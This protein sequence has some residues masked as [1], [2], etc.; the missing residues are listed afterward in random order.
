MANFQ[1]SVWYSAAAMISMV[2]PLVNYGLG[3]IKGSLA[4]WRYMFIVAGVITSLWG[5]VVL[6]VMESD[7][8]HAKSLNAR[9]KFIAVSRLREN[10]AGVRNTHFKVSQLWEV[11]TSAHF[12]LI[13][14]MAL[15][16]NVC[17]AVPTTFNPIIIADMGFSGF[18]ALLLTI[19]VGATGVIFTIGTAWLMQKYSHKNWRS[20]TIFLEVNGIVLVCV[21]FWQKPTMP[22]GA[23]LFLLYLLAFYPASYAIMMNLAIANCAGYTKK[24]LT[25]S[26]LFVGYCL[27]S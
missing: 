16:I 20:W 15:T 19:P 25:S 21:L 27:G 8:V 10:N 6:Y 2:A 26:G 12:W 13:F 9:E 22:I 1:L 4:P 17:N 24:A 11:L 5:F 23:K 7:P 18:N 14:F 3:H